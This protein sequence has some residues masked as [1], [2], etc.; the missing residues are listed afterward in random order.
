MRAEQSR[1]VPID[2]N[3]NR[4]SDDGADASINEQ[5]D[6]KIPWGLLNLE[7][8]AQQNATLIAIVNS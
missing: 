6:P 7:T 2:G 3:I 5:S 1:V 8:K 4:G